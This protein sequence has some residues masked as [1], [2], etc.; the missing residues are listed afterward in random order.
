MK[1][2]LKNALK[3][4]GIQI[5]RYP[6]SDQV[7]R[8]KIIHSY[9]INV[10]FDVGANTG[11]FALE[12][13][14]FGYIHKIISFEPLSSAFAPLTKNAL[15]DDN[16]IVNNYALGPKNTTG[17][18]NIAENSCSSSINN[19]FPKHIE[20]APDSIFIDKEEIE[21][22]TLDSIINSFCKPNEDNIMLKIDTQGYEKNVIDGA[23]N[24]LQTIKIIQ[25]EMSLVPLYENEML[26]QDMIDYLST[27]SFTLY[28]LE[29]GFINENSGQ[30]LQVDGIFVKNP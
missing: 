24:S 16:W 7:R 17:S 13:R 21:I 22:K 18:L 15:R 1:T 5:K 2:L 12:M 28:S 27:K 25:L 6:G 30:L 20:G 3:K 8:M 14:E 4:V 10:L 9:G 19:I 26:F 23:E 29:N 11:Q